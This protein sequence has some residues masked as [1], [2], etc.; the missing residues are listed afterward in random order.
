VRLIGTLGIVSPAYLT[1]AAAAV[2]R[3]LNNRLLFVSQP[4]IYI[5]NTTIFTKNKKGK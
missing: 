1:A 3:Y 5:L 4:Q 2:I